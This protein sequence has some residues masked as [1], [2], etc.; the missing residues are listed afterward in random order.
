MYRTCINSQRLVSWFSGFSRLVI[1]QESPGCSTDAVEKKTGSAAPSRGRRLRVHHTTQPP[2]GPMTNSS[3]PALMPKEMP[4]KSLSVIRIF[5]LLASNC[6]T[7]SPHAEGMAPGSDARWAYCTLAC[8]E[9]IF[10][11]HGTGND[12][13]SET[14]TPRQRH[15]FKICDHTAQL[16]CRHHQCAHLLLGLFDGVL[17]Q[18][19]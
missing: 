6:N 7:F 1:W 8:S 14:Y 5:P 3:E 4:S 11:F 16:T 19:S 18:A 10:A 12:L 9:P 17:H 2:C 15:M 13:T